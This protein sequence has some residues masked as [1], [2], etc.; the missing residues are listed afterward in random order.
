[1][2]S[3]RWVLSAFVVLAV[4]SAGCGDDN[5]VDGGNG[6][7]SISAFEM[8]ERLGRGVNFGN[9][10]EAPNEGEWG[11]TLQARHFERAAE[12]GFSTIRLP[13]RW[14]NHALDEPPYT[15][16]P[17]FF[18]RVDWALDRAEENGLNVVLNVHHYEEMDANPTEHKERWLAIW[19]QIAE[20]YQGRPQS[21]VF[22]L[23]NEPHDRLI[24]S[25]WNQY[26][27]EAIAVI[28]ESNP[29][30]NLIVGPVQW[31]STN[32]LPMLAL[33][34]DEH[35]IVTVHFYDPFQFTHQGA[36]WVSGS[37]AWLGTTWTGTVSQRAFIT[38]IL[39]RAANW[40]RDH[41]RP[42][43][44]GE[45]G[46]FERAD[47]TSRISWT[48]YVAREAERLEMSWAYWE[49]M[50]GFGIYII[51]NDTFR[52]GLVDALIPPDE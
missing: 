9:A 48:S 34:D 30:R 41:N 29:V 40:G 6:G 1:M 25:L 33:P 27:A 28:R 46:A 31:N 19:R 2:R 35:L 50:S 45:F 20:R 26:L 32:A 7:A 17:G 14:S 18:T 23:L 42:I 3:I 4:S 8:N 10:L 44:L 47:M 37:D 51:S 21:V 5:P 38:E 12:A 39:T 43:F 22:E 36:G 24:A 11:V 49:F 16:R 52:S 15:I 13:V